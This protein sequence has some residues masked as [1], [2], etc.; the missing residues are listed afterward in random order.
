MKGQYRLCILSGLSTIAA[1]D[2][3][4]VHLKETK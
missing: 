2:W 1:I 4:Y 3:K